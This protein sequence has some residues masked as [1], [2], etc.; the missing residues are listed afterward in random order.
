MPS[1]RSRPP[2]SGDTSARLLRAACELVG[3]EERLARRLGM[4]SL[5]LRRYMARGDELP[6]QLLLRTVDLLLQEREAESGLEG[7]GQPARP[8][9]PD[10][11]RPA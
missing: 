9:D 5:L 7:F 6:P 3:G 8:E 4:S 2:P 11:R 10:D 1:D